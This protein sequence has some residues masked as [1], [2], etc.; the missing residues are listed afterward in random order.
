MDSLA[1][2]IRDIVEFPIDFAGQ[3]K[4][5]KIVQLF[6]YASVIV[7]V[8]AGAISNNILGVVIAFVACIAA[9]FVLVLPPWPAYNKA[10]VKWLDVKYDLH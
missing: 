1:A 10:P 9:A 7:S 4:A 2:Q 3:E 5:H 6:L 8:L